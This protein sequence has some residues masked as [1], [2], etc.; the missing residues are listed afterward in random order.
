[1]DA[2]RIREIIEVLFQGGPGDQGGEGP[3]P[4]NKRFNWVDPVSGKRP[5]KPPRAML[6]TKKDFNALDQPGQ[7]PVGPGQQPATPT[8]IPIRHHNDDDRVGKHSLNDL[9][10]PGELATI[11]DLLDQYIAR[12]RTEGPDQAATWFNRYRPEFESIVRKIVD[13]MLG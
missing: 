6:P 7:P 2:A 9:I 3:E 1:M 13:F 10:P 12:Q 11:D 5:P 4:L 8:D